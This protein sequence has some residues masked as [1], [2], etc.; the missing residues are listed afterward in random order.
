MNKYDPSVAN[1]AANRTHLDM[2]KFGTLTMEEVMGEMKVFCGVCGDEKSIEEEEFWFECR[3]APVFICPT[4]Q[5]GRV[6]VPEWL[7]PEC[8][9]E[10]DEK[11]DEDYEYDNP[12]K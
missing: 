5:I 6:Y 2:R 4:C 10:E 11:L 7:M 9:G 3:T 1:R 12:P 8:V